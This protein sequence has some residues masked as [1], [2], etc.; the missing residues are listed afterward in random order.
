MTHHVFVGIDTDVNGAVA[1]L[2]QD[3]SYDGYVAKRFVCSTHAIPST[4]EKVGGK[5]RRIVNARDLVKLC[6]RVIPPYAYCTLEKQHAGSGQG[7]SSMFSFGR[8]YGSII[9][10]VSGV[11]HNSDDVFPHIEFV[12]PSMWKR[13]VG[14]TR[15]KKATVALA[16]SVAPDMAD[17]WRL[18]KH[19]SHAEAFLIALY[20]Y[21]RYSGCDF[22]TFR[23]WYFVKA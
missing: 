14:A 4:T 12:A 3:T 1:V 6:N 2:K 10:A 16:T 8:T 17:N 7:V 5:N 18:V 22:E 21:M 23:S 9:T 20:G 15:D 19:T 13:T 11:G